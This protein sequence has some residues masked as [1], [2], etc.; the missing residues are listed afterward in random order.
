ML[1]NQY[2]SESYKRKSSIAY[3]CIQPLQ[4]ISKRVTSYD[5]YYGGSINL[6]PVK[7][8]NNLSRWESLAAIK[9]SSYTRRRVAD[10]FIVQEPCAFSRNDSRWPSFDKPQINDNRN[11][12]ISRNRDQANKI[13]F[14]CAPLART[15][16]D[17]KQDFNS[18]SKP[19]IYSENW[20]ESQT[21]VDTNHKEDSIP[22]ECQ[23]SKKLTYSKR[24]NWKNRLT[25]D[26]F[27]ENA[28]SSQPNFSNNYWF[29]SPAKEYFDSLKLLGDKT[30]PKLLKN[31]YANTKFCSSKSSMSKDLW[32]GSHWS[33]IDDNKIQLN[34][35]RADS[36]KPIKV[37]NP[38]SILLSKVIHGGSSFWD[39]NYNN[40]NGSYLKVISMKL[41]KLLFN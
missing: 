39:K 10:S 25:F 2:R 4:P 31:T 32:E 34:H 27:S 22:S 21:K 35:Q 17:T 18:Y 24:Q 37:F 6:K 33:I 12:H 1:L 3:E 41:F 5:P 38:E 30:A 16:G 20:Q 14:Y 13:D 7:E 36:L 23:F 9:R 26:V 28:L 29:K 40:Q 11:D 19:L 8:E 15:F